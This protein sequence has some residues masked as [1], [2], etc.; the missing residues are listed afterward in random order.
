MEAFGKKLKEEFLIE[1]EFVCVNHSSFGFVPK[2]IVE[3]RFE[4]SRKFL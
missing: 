4:N 1:P 3:Q 2:Q